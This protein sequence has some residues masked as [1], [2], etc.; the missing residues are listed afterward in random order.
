MN[1]FLAVLVLLAMPHFAT[2]AQQEQPGR[3]ASVNGLKLYDRERGGN[4][5]TRRT[6]IPAAKARRGWAN[7]FSTRNAAMKRSSQP[8]FHSTPKCYG[9][10]QFIW[11]TTSRKESNTKP[12]TIEIMQDSLHGKT[13][14]VTG[15]SR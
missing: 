9:L 14:L 1:K 6:C 2:N 10:R 13:A 12:S 4:F 11:R 3:Y 8:S 7:S 15:G 5:S